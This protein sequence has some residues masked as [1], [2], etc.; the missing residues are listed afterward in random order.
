MSAGPSRREHWMPWALL[1][2]F[3]VVALLIGAAGYWAWYEQAR[4]LRAQA[5][6]SLTAV[7]HLK[8]GQIASWIGERRGDAEVEHHDRLLA[9]ASADILSGQG[10]ATTTAQ[11]Q[12]LLSAVQRHQGYAAVLL[13]APDSSV[14]LHAPAGR[15][16]AQIGAGTA[17]L[18]RR[19]VLEDRVE[20]SDLY[21]DAAGH[22]AIDFVAPLQLTGNRGHGLAAVVLRVNP[23]TFLFPLIQSWPTKSLSGESLLV[24]RRGGRVL[25]LNELRFRRGT[26]LRLGHALSDASLP[27]AMAVR[28]VRGVVQGVDYRGT[29]VLA[30]LESVEGTPWSL[31]AKIDTQEVLGPVRVRAWVTAGV[32]ALIIVLAGVGALRLWRT[33]EKQTDAELDAGEARYRALFENMTEGVALNELVTDSTGASIDYVLVDMNAAFAAQMGL[34]AEE[35]RGRLASDSLGGP[36][37]PFLTEYSTTMRVGAARL[38]ETFYA[39]RDRYFEIAVAPQGAGAFTTMLTDV[40]ARKRDQQRVKAMNAELEERVD[41]R[42]SQ[43]DAA[44]KELEAFA[45]SVSHDLRAPLRHVSGFCDLLVGRAGESLDE[46][47]RHY[48]DVIVKSA[49]QMGVLIDDLLEFSRSG[50]AELRLQRVDMRQAIDEALGPL[51]DEIAARG[52]DCSIGL[53]PDVSGDPAVLRQVWANL[54]GNAVKYTRGTTP[55]RIEVGVVGDVAEDDEVASEDVFFVK[56][57]GV[58][59]DMQYAHKLF[60]VFQRLHSAA[61]FEGTGI[62]LA[63]VK[64]GIAR[65]GG[66]VWAEAAL[67]EGATFYFSLPRGQE[68]T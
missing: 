59:F 42:T 31:V 60:G 1:A 18:V 14:L 3:A 58:G 61:E 47:S 19:A 43:L 45:Y 9:A 10:S 23:G 11:V 7:G 25:Y 6:R 50:R 5:E 64:R 37:P 39:P 4:S 55:A 8:A 51:R 2:G 30:D 28:G 35:A 57:N 52:V 44:N 12:S 13:V 21:L 67:G 26:A 49:G 48:V 22:A 40:T 36:P 27:A 33:R 62:G 65:L 34:D 20:S 54:L 66:R 16:A 29:R 15:A 63:N 53:L 68:T 17:G 24:E 56:D 32:T 46:R 38:F 41:Q